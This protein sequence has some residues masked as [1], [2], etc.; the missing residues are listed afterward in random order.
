MISPFFILVSLFFFHSAPAA[1]DAPPWLYDGT[2]SHL[3][4]GAP[5]RCAVRDCTCRVTRGEVSPAN[6]N[7]ETQTRQQ[8]IY[9]LENEHSLTNSQ[10]TDIR[11]FASRFTNEEQVDITIIGYTDGC[12]TPV[13]NQVLSSNRADVVTAQIRRVL[14][15]AEISVRSVVERASGH[16]PQARRVDVITHTK[17]N[18][19]TS[20]EKVP[21]DA[22]LI[23]ASGSMWSGWDGWNDVVNASL[24]P[25]SK[26]YISKMSGC[27]NGMSLN[28]VEP[29][30]GTEI[31][32]SYWIVLSRI[33]QGS[34]L[35]I[36][37]D[38][39][40]NY[41]LRGWEAQ[42]IEEK[43]REKQIR[44]IAIRP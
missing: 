29:G 43:V 42:M 25:G 22:Y 14:P 24:R 1:E 16:S 27:H 13:A 41:P 12:G 21:A 3:G 35:A 15:N 19:T 10:K 32:Y 11:T 39:N 30:G 4:G 20:I 37:S 8:S 38:F 31:W 28:A 34:T 23:D 18:F 17:S 9:F 7:T 26:I 44:V 6:S 33:S 2:I 40:A 36:I 5:A